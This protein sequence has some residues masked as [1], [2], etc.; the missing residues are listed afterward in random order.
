MQSEIVNVFY[1]STLFIHRYDSLWEDSGNRR[2][3]NND[4]VGS[5][6]DGRGVVRSVSF[7]PLDHMVAF[8]AKNGVAVFKHQGR[9]GGQI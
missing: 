2:V 7:H 4:D 8:G 6:V 1:Q 9:G 3:D 5:G